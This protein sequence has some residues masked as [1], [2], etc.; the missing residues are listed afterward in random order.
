[1]VQA[2]HEA[3]VL[4]QVFGKHLNLRSLPLLPCLRLASPPLISCDTLSLPSLFPC[5]LRV[6]AFH[7]PFFPLHPYRGLFMIA[8]AILFVRV[9]VC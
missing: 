9:V 7:S 6:P 3:R 2:G 4:M 1:M 5:A 8:F